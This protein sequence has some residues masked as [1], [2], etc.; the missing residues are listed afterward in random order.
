MTTFLTKPTFEAIM[1][2]KSIA[3]LFPKIQK[4]N[5]LVAGDL[6]LDRYTFGTCRRIS[7]EAPVPVIS[8]TGEE[9]RPGGAG[10]VAVNL[11]SLGQNPIIFGRVG[12][13]AA[14]SALLQALQAEGISTGDIFQ[15]KGFQ[16][17]LKVRLIAASQQVTR[18]DYETF[19][20]I[21]QEAEKILCER[22]EPLLEQIDLVAISDYAKGFLTENILSRLIHEARSRN[23]PVISDPKGIEL[24]KYAGSTIL[25][26]NLQE[27]YAAAP[28]CS[29]LADVARQIFQQAP[30]DILMVTRS[31]AGISLFYPD[32]TNEH[33][34]VCPRQ[35]KDVTGAGDTV[36]AVLSA[37]VANGIAVADATELANIGGQIAIERL[38]CARVSLP[39]LARAYAGG[40][41]D[42]KIFDEAH[43]PVLEQALQPGTYSLFTLDA[44]VCLTSKLLREVR[45]QARDAKKEIVVALLGPVVDEE[46]VHTLAS[47]KE[48]AYLLLLSSNCDNVLTRLVPH[49]TVSFGAQA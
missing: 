28:S 13:D 29:E 38:G 19:R 12:T 36:L 26:P 18:I 33:H 6:I 20:P 43:I 49:E 10:N 30:V 4:K 39:D 16:T 46:L 34:P 15:E 45:G 2:A 37:A 9:E 14:G 1:A 40:H 48:V 24:A 3:H 21:S 47:I 17:P 42:N 32:G 5:I 22:I 44:N 35:V 25:K 31:E 7:P 8:V 23:I 11:L 27:A 41:S